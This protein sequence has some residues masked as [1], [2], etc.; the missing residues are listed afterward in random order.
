[1]ST[2]IFNVDQ[3]SQIA[4][5]NSQPPARDNALL[6]DIKGASAFLG[7]TLWQIRGLISSQELLVVKVGRK[8]YLR[9]ATLA[10]WA[11]RVEGKHR[12]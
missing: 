1:V 8:L 2:I 3:R 12:V 7:L 5:T 11:E 4:V 9:K 10:R 6:L